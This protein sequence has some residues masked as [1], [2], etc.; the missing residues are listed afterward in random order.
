MYIGFSNYAFCSCNAD[1]AKWDKMHEFQLMTSFLNISNS[2]QCCRSTSYA[3]ATLISIGA[4]VCT[5]LDAG[6]CKTDITL[7]LRDETLYKALKRSPSAK[8]HV[9]L[10]IA[11]Y[12]WGKTCRTS[13]TSID[14]SFIN[15]RCNS[16]PCQRSLR[17]KPKEPRIVQESNNIPLR[18][19]WNVIKRLCVHSY[20]LFQFVRPI[21][22][23][24]QI[25]TRTIMKCW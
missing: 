21:S 23:T 19:W 24:V 20:V 16:R 1:Y 3:V 11:H 7:Q 18:W 17:T 25:F 8:K 5:P 15:R 13:P 2:I 14:R 6:Q 9:Y 4:R 22:E 12:R 10:Y